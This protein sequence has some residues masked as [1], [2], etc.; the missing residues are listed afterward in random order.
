MQTFL[1]ISIL[2]SSLFNV[3]GSINVSNTENPVNITSVLDDT[4]LYF[5]DLRKFRMGAKVVPADIK[6]YDGQ[7]VQ[8]VGFMVPFDSIEKLDKFILLQAPFMGCFHIPPPQPNESVLINSKQ[9][10]S[11]Y[12]YEPIRIIGKLKIEETYIENYLV[13]M[14]T[15]EA[16][17]IEVVSQNDAELEGLPASFHMF[18]EF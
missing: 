13:S 8:I 17:K 3:I 2:F 14:Y 15:I 11:D 9:M 1:I 12:T 4:Q 7:S 16:T 5:K 6:K 18:G 10:P